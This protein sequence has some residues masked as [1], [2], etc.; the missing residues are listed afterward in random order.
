MNERLISVFGAVLAL[1]AVI[2]L[3][4]PAPHVEAPISRPLSMDRG[5]HGLHAL[6]RWIERG[7]ITVVSLQQR[8]HA[9]PEVAVGNRHLLITTLPVRTLTRADERRALVDWISAGN[10]LLL[11]VAKNT[12]PAWAQTQTE[13]DVDLWR[14]LAL[15]RNSR[16]VRIPLRPADGDGTSLTLQAG[17]RHPL[18]TG[19]RHLSVDVRSVPARTP[20]AGVRENRG[21]VAK[22]KVGS[23]TISD[24]LWLRHLGAGRLIV[25]TDTTMFANARLGQADNARLLNN[26]LGL[27]LRPGGGVIVDDM[28][29]GISALYDP[30]AFAR[31]RR[32]HVSVMFMLGL[33]LAW[34]VGHGNRFGPRQSVQPHESGA[35]FARA[36]GG[37]LAR[38]ASPAA[39]AG[40]LIAA[41]ERDCRRRYPERCATGF[42]ATAL[43]KWPAM[44]APATQGFLEAERALAAG[45]TPDLI[46]LANDLRTLRNCL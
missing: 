39:V 17:A 18:F 21:A 10:T 28:H 2:S 5:S 1:I 42:S 19:V 41:F 40:A 15:D 7:H 31:D 44:P 32:V 34:I 22:P 6:F 38:Q 30:V 33:W 11:L 4:V 45:R 35:R 29:Q 26:L 27:T 23:S 8:Y 14:D 20:A 36:V 9:L 16:G 37:L 13:I 24:Y 43:A 12:T 46:V 25:A 3:V